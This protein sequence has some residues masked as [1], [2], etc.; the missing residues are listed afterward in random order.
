V[1][2]GA[3][4][5]AGWLIANQIDLHRNDPIS[6]PSPQAKTQPIGEGLKKLS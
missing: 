4:A 6:P 2:W 1:V 5:L 3:L